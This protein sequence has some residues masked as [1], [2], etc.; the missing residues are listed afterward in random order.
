MNEI[1]SSLRAIRSAVD[2]A[3]NLTVSLK[4]D[5]RA[6]ASAV[7]LEALTF[8]LALFL[9]RSCDGD[10]KTL[11]VL[12]DGSSSHLYETAAEINSH[13]FRVDLREARRRVAR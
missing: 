13:D 9:V 5:S 6:S 12:L 1:G 3:I 2:G 8:E 7:L 11:A 10:E 4:G